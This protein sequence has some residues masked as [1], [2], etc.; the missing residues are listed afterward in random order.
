PGSSQLGL[1]NGGPD[2]STSNNG[3][4]HQSSHW[5]AQDFNGGVLIGIM[6]PSIGSGIRRTIRTNDT[7]A[8]NMFGYSVENS[9]PP[10]PASP[11][12]VPGNDNFANAHVLSDCAGSVFGTT[13]GATLESGE[14]GHDPAGTAG[15]GSVWY[16]WQA[17]T[18]GSVTMTTTG[19]QTDFDT[20]LAIYTGE[21]VSSLV[22]ITK[23]DDINPGIVRTS[24]VTFT[25]TAGTIYK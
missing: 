8:L 12:P 6:D 19:G 1:S 16:Q 3:D 17:Q 11:L 21:A 20:V 13:L 22:A 23:N 24:Q 4:G 25:A 14:P 7:N 2:G 9:N 5:R 15:G 10:P 18:S